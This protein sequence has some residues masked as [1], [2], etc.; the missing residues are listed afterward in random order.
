MQTLL[1]DELVLPVLIALLVSGRM[2]LTL[3]HRCLYRAQPLIWLHRTFYSKLIRLLNRIIENSRIFYDEIKSMSLIDLLLT[4]IFLDFAQLILL[5]HKLGMPIVNTVETRCGR[6]FFY[7]FVFAVVCIW[8]WVHIFLLSSLL[9]V[10][11]A[12]L[13]TL[14]LLVHHMVSQESVLH[15]Y[16]L[17]VEL[18]RQYRFLNLFSLFHICSRQLMLFNVFSILASTHWRFPARKTRYDIW[19]VHTF[20]L[21][22]FLLHLID[23]AAVSVLVHH[24]VTL[25]IAAVMIHW[26]ACVSGWIIYDQIDWFVLSVQIWRV[27][28]AAH[29]VAVL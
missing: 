21:D 13:D 25:M 4:I 2:K 7:S 22:Q 8:I 10:R 6:Q 29:L 20:L 26:Y 1:V 3:G 17:D 15:I 23:L 18:L 9:I 28:F 16:L 19:I 27:E 5:L 12:G 11:V 24:L 14:K